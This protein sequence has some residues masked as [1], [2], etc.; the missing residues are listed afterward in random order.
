MTLQVSVGKTYQ[1]ASGRTVTIHTDRNTCVTFSPFTY[2]FIGNQGTSYTTEGV[3][4]RSPVKFN[5]VS[6]IT[7]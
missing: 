2:R 5:L 7:K 6:E 1:D 4:R 3:A